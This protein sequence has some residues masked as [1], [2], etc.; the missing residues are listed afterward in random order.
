MFEDN[1]EVLKEKMHIELLE[2]FDNMKRER[3]Y[4][5]TDSITDSDIESDS[6]SDDSSI[7]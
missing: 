2:Y 5:D 7:S 4:S 3:F 1:Y 6:S